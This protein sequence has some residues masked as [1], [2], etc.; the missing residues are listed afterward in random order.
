MKWEYKVVYIAWGENPWERLIGQISTELNLL[1]QQGWELVSQ[2]S[3]ATRGQISVLKRQ[4][5]K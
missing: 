1:G 3:Y 4:I 2:T 5:S